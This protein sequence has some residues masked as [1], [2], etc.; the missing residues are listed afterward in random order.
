MEV[1]MAKFIPTLGPKGWINE[2]QAVADYI[3]TSF[4]TVNKSQSNLF[5]DKSDS[6]QSILAEHTNDVFGLQVKLQE[7]LTAKLLGTF[8]ANSVAEVKVTPLE[9]KPDQFKINFLGRVYADG[10]EY[11]IGKLVH[12]V[13]SKVVQINEVNVNG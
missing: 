8:E 10:V 11:I 9:D 6:F 7:V 12:T 2:P 1:K 5:R 4:L 3:L 13:D